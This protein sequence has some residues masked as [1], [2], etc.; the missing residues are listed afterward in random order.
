MIRFNPADDEEDKG[1]VKGRLG[2]VVT[3]ADILSIISPVAVC[4]K[5]HN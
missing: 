4:R 2:T 3:E 5:H 1:A